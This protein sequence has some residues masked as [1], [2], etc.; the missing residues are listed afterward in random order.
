MLGPSCSITR[1]LRRVVLVED[2]VKDGLAF[3]PR[4]ERPPPRRGDELEFRLTYGPPEREGLG[5]YRIE[6]D[7]LLL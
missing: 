1:D 2:G 7:G 6:A 4:R 3:Q 5:H